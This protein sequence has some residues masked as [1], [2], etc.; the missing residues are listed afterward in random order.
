MAEAP[1]SADRPRLIRLILNRAETEDPGEVTVV[2]QRP[3]R[4][5]VADLLGVTEGAALVLR[6]EGLTSVRR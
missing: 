2:E 4:A 3:A 5:V 6:C 1:S